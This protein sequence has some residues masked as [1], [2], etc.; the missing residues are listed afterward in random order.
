MIL[1]FK[2]L[3][4][5]RAI[6]KLLERQS[7]LHEGAPPTDNPYIRFSEA[8]VGGG[9]ALQDSITYWDLNCMKEL[10]TPSKIGIEQ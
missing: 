5:Y 1:F 4:P 3:K 7:L 6:Q 8:Q 10:L 9:P 2:R